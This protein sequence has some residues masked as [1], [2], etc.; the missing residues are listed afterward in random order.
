MDLG[1]AIFPASPPINTLGWYHLFLFGVLVPLTAIRSRRRLLAAASVPSRPLHYAST[2][3]L[4]VMF[5]AISLWTARVQHVGLAFG[6]PTTP[7]IVAGAIVLVV[8]VFAVMPRWRKAVERDDPLARLYAPT[9]TFEGA[10]WALK[11]V[12]AGIGEEISW[13]GVQ[14]A[15]LGLAFGNSALALVLSVIGFTVGHAYQGRKSLPII[16]CFAVAFH[17]LVVISG[18]LLVPIAVHAAYDAVAGLAYGRLVRDAKARHRR[19]IASAS[20]APESS[21]K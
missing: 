10:L 11:A 13:R 20:I 21:M 6:R 3:L 8:G 2:M 18:S 4:Q 9:T 17:A 15:L 14:P 16:A 5:A 19:A 12:L 7:G 1:A